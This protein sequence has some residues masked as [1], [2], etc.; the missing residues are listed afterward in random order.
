[1]KKSNIII[2]AI[3]I[4]ISFF[5]LWLWYYL[6]FN[7]VDNPLDL[8]LS[9]VWWVISAV[10]IFG[11]VRFEKKRRQQ[12]RTIYVAPGM[13][14]NSER[15]A[16]ECVDPETRIKLMQDI[17]A[18]LKYGFNKEDLPDN[19]QYDFQYVVRTDD[20]DQ[21][22]S[23][24]QQQQ[25]ETEWKGTVVKIDRTQGNKECSFDTKQA[26]VAALA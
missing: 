3:L 16:V 21:K 25:D 12:I 26:L 4:A 9:I 23:S 13:L 10:L 6:G 11:I 24:D 1:M 17:L 7:K 8:V 15:G 19:D 18:N 5:L 22:N 20:F 14:F 2:F